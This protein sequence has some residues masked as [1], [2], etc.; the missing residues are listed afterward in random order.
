LNQIEAGEIEFD[1]TTLL[2]L[3]KGLKVTPDR[4]LAFL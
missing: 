2:A 3:A 4:L 1:Y